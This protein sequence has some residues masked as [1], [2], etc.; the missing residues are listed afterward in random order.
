MRKKSLLE[1]IRDKEYLESL[2]ERS[3]SELIAAISVLNPE[4]LSKIS[5]I[6]VAYRIAREKWIKMNI[7]QIEWQEYLEGKPLFW[8]S[9]VMLNKLQSEEIPE[10]GTVET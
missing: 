1:K 8:K 6:S 2:S 7:P 4:E 10:H 5:S 3:R 9:F